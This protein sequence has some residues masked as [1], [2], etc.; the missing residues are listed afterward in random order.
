MKNSVKTERFRH[1]WEDK[2]KEI[3]Q[4]E[5]KEHEEMKLGEK[6]IRK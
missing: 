3:L 6:N 2:V 4:K 5:E 1:G